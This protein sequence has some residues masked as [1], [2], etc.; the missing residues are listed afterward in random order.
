M[1]T[2]SNPRGEGVAMLHVGLATQRPSMADV[3]RMIQS[4]A[5]SFEWYRSHY[6]LLLELVD[7]SEVSFLTDLFKFKCDCLN[8]NLIV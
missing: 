5:L 6:C 8:L 1:W 4:V 7:G 3:V 2:C